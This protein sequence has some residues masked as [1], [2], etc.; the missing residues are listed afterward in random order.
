[1]GQMLRERRREHLRRAALD[2]RARSLGHLLREVAHRET[3]AAYQRHVLRILAH[4]LD[5]D[6]RCAVAQHAL[7]DLR[8]CVAA[9]DPDGDA[10]VLHQLQRV[11]VPLQ[12]LLER[13]YGVSSHQGLPCRVAGDGQ[14]AHGGASGAKHPHVLRMILH[15]DDEQLGHAAGQQRAPHGDGV[16]RQAVDG[17][18]AD[19][20]HVRALGVRPH[21][22]RDQPHRASGQHREAPGVAAL[23]D[24]VDG[25]ACRSLYSGV[26]PMAAHHRREYR[27]HPIAHQ[28][29]HDGVRMAILRQLQHH[30]AAA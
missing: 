7:A 26:Q 2:H 20:L 15:G 24:A 12:R 23:G 16:G 19:L 27:T 18:T 25:G 13:L 14:V 1:M 10:D 4:H 11:R 28:R 6:V 8:R 21:G 17:P 5:G 9:Q 3:S 30:G 22:V 29:V